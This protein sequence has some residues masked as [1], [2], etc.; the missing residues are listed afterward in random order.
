MRMKL[1]R[2]ASVSGI[3]LATIY[4]SGCRHP[5]CQTTIPI[6]KG[7]EPLGCVTV[8]T[9]NTHLFAGSREESL[10]LFRKNSLDDRQRAA[11]MIYKIAESRA[12]IVALQ[13]VW[14]DGNQEWFCQKLKPFYQYCFVSGQKE[15]WE[16]YK[17]TG[18][19]NTCGLVLLSKYKF[20]EGPTFFEY[21]RSKFK[22]GDPEGW[23]RK[24]GI[25]ATVEL[26]PGGPKLR[27]GITHTHTGHG[28]EERNVEQL[29]NATIKSGR[30]ID[31]PAII[32][33]DFNVHK[34]GYETLKIALDGLG[35]VDAYLE[36]HPEIGENDYTIDWEKNALNREFF[37]KRSKHDRDR[38][39][40]V[41]IKKSGGG[42]EVT[43]VEAE[44]LR[45]WK[46][47]AVW[48]KLFRRVKLL[49]DLSDHYPLKVRF[50]VRRAASPR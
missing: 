34:N 1:F 13:E 10:D 32:M 45:D 29:A 22:F 36:V 3:L 42:L 38:I 35:A 24:G 15:D 19:L 23:A 11:K 2:R 39:D 12:D 25:F 8:L 7:Q 28:E 37:P 21:D 31:C 14:A 49:A 48:Q 33:G 47:N 50:E 46:Y 26:R 43:L 41:F 20:I 4:V 30:F 16:D 6:P 17:K 9:Y 40:Y 44:V 5:G 18:Y 27:L